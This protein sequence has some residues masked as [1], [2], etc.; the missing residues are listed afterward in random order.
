MTEITRWICMIIVVACMGCDQ[1]NQQLKQLEMKHDLQ[2]IVL[3]Y[4]L[5]DAARG[6]SPLNANELL[7]Y[8]DPE[9]S[10][11]PGNADT[12]SSA[13]KALQSGNYVVV[14]KV[15]L[16]GTAEMNAGKVLAYH[17]DVPEKGGHVCYQDGEAAVLTREEFERAPK[18]QPAPDRNTVANQRQTEPPQELPE[19]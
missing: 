5:F 9:A 19:R 15:K 11:L 12:Q 2:A 8:E 10:Y 18:S 16:L 6:R 7:D 13:R 4:H 3:T 17:R 14:W 1:S